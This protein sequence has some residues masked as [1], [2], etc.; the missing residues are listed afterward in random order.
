VL[1]EK[2]PFEDMDILQAALVIRD[3]SRTPGIPLECPTFLKTILELCWNKDPTKRP[4]MSV[5]N[6]LFRASV[7]SDDESD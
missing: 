1:S 3:E 6:Q 2:A 7:D 4:E 5:V